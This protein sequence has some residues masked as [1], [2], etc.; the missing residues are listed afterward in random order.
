MKYRVSQP[1]TQKQQ[2]NF[3]RRLTSTTY[4]LPII[5]LVLLAISS[6]VIPNNNLLFRPAASTGAAISIIEPSYD[7]TESGTF[8]LVAKL[9]GYDPGGYDMFW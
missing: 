7:A 2:T 9:P 6:I 8:H 3:F 5:L 1:V 4:F